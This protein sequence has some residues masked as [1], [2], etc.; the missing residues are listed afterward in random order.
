MYTE[1]TNGTHFTRT[2]EDISTSLSETATLKIYD[3]PSTEGHETSTNVHSDAS[4]LS[5]TFQLIYDGELSPVIPVTASANQMMEYLSQMTSLA[6]VPVVSKTQGGS[7]VADTVE[8]VGVGA[9]YVSWQFTFD[10]RLGDAKKLTFKYTDALGD[11][12]VTSNIVGSGG[13]KLKNEA[14]ELEHAGTTSRPTRYISNKIVML[15]RSGSAFY[16]KIDD[17]YDGAATAVDSQTGDNYFQDELAMDVVPGTKLS[18]SSAEV[19]HTY[20]YQTVN[21]AAE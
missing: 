2:L 10:G 15:Y 5:G 6:H 8:A 21:E 3:A 14:K 12:Q 20:L 19:H 1:G 13:A 17:D 4:Q 7:S 11:E 18:V 16:D 9:D